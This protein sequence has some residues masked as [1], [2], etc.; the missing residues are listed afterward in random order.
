MPASRRFLLDTNIVIALL[1]G[2]DTVLS[3]LDQAAEVFIPAV[4]VDERVLRSRE[5]RPP[6]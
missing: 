1:Q 5:I 6:V 2:D 3:N 4:A